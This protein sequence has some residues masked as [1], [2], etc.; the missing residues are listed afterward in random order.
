VE[1]TIQPTE[2][3]SSGLTPLQ[4]YFLVRLEHVLQLRFEQ[5]GNLNEGGAQLL[6]RTIYSTYCDCLD[7]SVGTKAQEIMHQFLVVNPQQQR[8]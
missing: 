7:L 2:V 4:S 1:D 5:S 3:T 8:N 6:D